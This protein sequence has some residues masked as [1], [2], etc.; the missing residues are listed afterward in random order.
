MGYSPIPSSAAATGG[1]VPAGAKVS[2][3]VE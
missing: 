1:P 3:L 2:T